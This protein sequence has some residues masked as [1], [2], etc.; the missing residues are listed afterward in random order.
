MVKKLQREG[1]SMKKVKYRFSLNY[2]KEEEWINEMSQQ[3]WH[4]EKFSFGRFTFI[5]GEA[6]E[7][8]YRSELLGDMGKKEKAE[9][10]E[11]LTDSG[12]TV[13]HEFAGW[14]Y[15]RRA[16]SEGP[17]ELF[18][19]NQSYIGYYQRILR[20]MI[21]LFLINLF[22]AFLNLFVSGVDG[23]LGWLNGS[24][25][26]INALVTLILLIPLGHVYR[27]KSKLEKEQQFFE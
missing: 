3:G 11:F 4:L 25:G 23:K 6:G 9:Y 19:S 17:F 26:S 10:L 8:I 16:A 27:Q 15:T 21:P 14:I 2:Q 18:T 13:V 5:K 20:Y 1:M 12:I 7:F 22:M 24:V